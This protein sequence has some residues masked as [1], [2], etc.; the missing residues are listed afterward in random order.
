MVKYTNTN[1]SQY[2][3]YFIFTGQLCLSI[4]LGGILGW[5]REKIGKAA[6]PRTYALVS[7]G[8]TL[9]T[10]LSTIFFANSDPSRIASQIVVGIGFLGA[11]M[12]LHKDGGVVEGLTTAA[13]FWAVAAIGMAVGIGWYIQSLIA[14]LLMFLVLSTDDQKLKKKIF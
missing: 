14:T 8:S 10:I 12:I 6:G 3:M 2:M 4:F 9:F 5:Q 1:Y 7:F 13:G 11:G